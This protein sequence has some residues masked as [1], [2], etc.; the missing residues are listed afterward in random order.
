[1]PRNGPYT[2]R[3]PQ[4]FGP[5]PQVRW[6]TGVDSG[7][8]LSIERAMDKGRSW[9][10]SEGIALERLASECRDVI[11][12]AFEVFCKLIL[13]SFYDAVRA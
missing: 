4:R 12:T 13:Q 11:R 5:I 1:V 3:L 9:L 7:F 10:L 6:A 8:P 2:V